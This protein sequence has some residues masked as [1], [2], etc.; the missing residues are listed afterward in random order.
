MA[1]MDAVILAVFSSI[2]PCIAVIPSAG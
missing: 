2:C 1:L